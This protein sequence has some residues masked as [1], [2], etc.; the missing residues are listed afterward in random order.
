[1]SAAPLVPLSAAP[2]S[3]RHPDRSAR[4]EAPDRA[5]I[6][7]GG[8]ARI[9]LAGVILLAGAVLL[10]SL[11]DLVTLPARQALAIF[12]V[13]VVA[14]VVLQLDETPVALAAG[15][16]LVL[17]GVVPADRL[18]AALG[19]DLVWLLLGGFVVAAALQAAGLAERWALGLVRGSRSVASLVMRLTLGIAAT[20]FIVPSTSA[21]A[22]LLLPVFLVVARVIGDPRVTRAL[23]LLFP[24]VILLSAGASLLG[25]GAHLIAVDLLR[26]HGLEAPDLLRWAWLAAP[27][28]LA[29]SLAAAALILLRFLSPGERRRPIAWPESAA[30][31]L[32]APQRR[33][34]AIA[35]ASVGAF[36]AAPSLGVEPA[37][38]ALAAA[39]L[40]TVRPLTSVDLA[41]ALRRVEWNLLLFLAAT[42]VLGQAM[43]DTGAAD[44]LARLAA[45]LLT[46][47]RPP[48][49]WIALA[50]IVALLAHLA[51]TSRTARAVVL[52]PAVALPIAA[53][54]GLNPVV[55]V[56]VMVLGSGYCQTLVVSAKP[57]L[58][59]SHT[60]LPTYSA[61]DLLHLSALLGPLVLVLLVIVATWI[62]PLQALP[63]RVG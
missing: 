22:V 5:R 10:W 16:A 54:S 49:A 52:L 32:T 17:L 33:T 11:R 61:R 12:G 42:L 36:A 47:E 59:Y 46:R 25:A 9:V 3:D 18:F 7:W 8:R 26:H 14:W 23:A 50:A 45:P 4:H 13:A 62:W 20:A 38:V 19:A 31:P 58:L 43:V 48:L 35:L 1:M 41:S 55:I 51:I 2:T 53:A 63:L 40:I 29:C 27:F 37:L 28:S 6:V 57:V 34:G 30:G 24:S 39:L 15:L 21:R 56:M 44:A 60:E